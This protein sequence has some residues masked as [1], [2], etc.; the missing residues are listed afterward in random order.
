MQQPEAFVM[1][2]DHWAKYSNQKYYMWNIKNLTQASSQCLFFA[3]FN[4]WLFIFQGKKLMIEHTLYKYIFK[5]EDFSFR[6][7][8]ILG[9]KIQNWWS[10]WAGS[11]SEEDKLAVFHSTADMISFRGLLFG[12][13]EGTMKQVWCSVWASG[14]TGNIRNGSR[15]PF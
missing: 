9:V 7:V 13:Q 2:P 11:N 14:Y 6:M 15:I 12:P 4:S 5:D 1:M 8:V 10:E 3:P